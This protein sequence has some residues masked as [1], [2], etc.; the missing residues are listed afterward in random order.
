LCLQQS[1]K[2]KGPVSLVLTVFAA[3]AIVVAVF[4]VHLIFQLLWNITVP[5]IFGLRTIRYWQA[6]HLLL[7]ASMIFGA[8]NFLHFNF[9]Q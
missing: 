7:M 4:F 5:E 3:L 9:N 8:G 6:F 2:I 1:R